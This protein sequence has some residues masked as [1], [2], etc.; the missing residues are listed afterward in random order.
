MN[1]P[2]SALTPLDESILNMKVPDLTTTESSNATPPRE[3]SPFELRANPMAIRGVPQIPLRPQSKIAFLPNWTELASLDPEKFREWSEIQRDDFDAR[4]CN[5]A[6]CAFATLDGTW[7][8]ELDKPGMR[9]QIENETGENFPETFVVESSPGKGHFYFHQTAA[10]IKMGN[11]QGKDEDGETWSARVDNRYVVSPGSIHPKTGKTYDVVNDA[12]IVPAPDWL[13]EWCLKNAVCEA[14]RVNA[15]PDGPPIPRGSHDNELFRIACCLRNAGLG[16]DQILENLIQVCEKRC[17]DHGS[18]YVEM[19]QVKTAQACKYP[20]TPAPS[21]PLIGGKTKEE[22]S[23]EWEEKVKREKEEQAWEEEKSRR[24][25]QEIL[26]TQARQKQDAKDRQAKR[27]QLIKEQSEQSSRKSAA[28]E[29]D[30]DEIPEFDESCITGIY[31]DIVTLAVKGT[32]IPPQFALLNAKVYFGALL[33]GRVSFEGLDSDSS[34][35]GT[36]IGETGTSKGESWRRTIEA[37]LYPEFLNLKQQTLKIIYS[38]DSGAGLKDCFFEPPREV[39]VVCYVDEVGSLGHKGSEKKSP[40]IIDTIVELA[41][42]HRVSRVL[43]KKGKLGGSKTHDNA[44]LSLYM[45]GQDGPTFMSAFAGRTKIGLFDRFYPEFS[46]PIEAGDL[47]EISQSEVLELHKKIAALHFTGKMTMSDATLLD[48]GIFWSAQPVEIRRKIRFRKYLMLDMY[49]A[50]FGRGVTCAEP[51]DLAVAIK[52]FTRQ[53]VIRRVHFTG[54][55]PD[56]VGFYEGQLQKLTERMH[57]RLI[58]GAPIEEVAMSLVDFQNLSNAYRDREGRAFDQAWRTH[59]KRLTKV[60]VIGAN[61]HK[62]DKFVPV[63]LE[64]ETWL[65]LPIQY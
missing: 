24:E 18:D 4:E 23:A 29:P 22:L 36:V 63:P 10:S 38:A 62:Y 35:Y 55:V 3:L 14:G 17:V 56:R 43:A 32:T 8:F 19:C 6:S 46:G 53:I 27:D 57:R 64:D 50:A 58:S 54:E 39:P 61:G 37:I 13:V 2:A 34:Y 51:E 48:L 15:S 47:P 7:F 33:A 5:S 44:R 52:M 45:C 49:M 42:S 65:P 9:K 20:V 21:I 31:R 59:V 11:T 16:H 41:D 30:E 26:E 25:Q 40:E 60:S 28:P 12:E 1:A